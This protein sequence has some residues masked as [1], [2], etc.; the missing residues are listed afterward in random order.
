MVR[1]RE[2][3]RFEAALVAGAGL[4]VMCVALAPL[5]ILSTIEAVAHRVPEAAGTMAEERGIDLVEGGD[6]VALPQQANGVKHSDP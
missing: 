6:A 5:M 1:A 4:A 3:K 2:A